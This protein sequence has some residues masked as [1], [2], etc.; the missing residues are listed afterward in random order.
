[1][2][3]QD[4]QRA[5]AQAA[6]Q[7]HVDSYEL[8]YQTSDRT[9]VRVF[10][11]EVNEFTSAVKGG[12]CLRCAIDGKMGYASTEELSLPAAEALVRRAADNAASLES[13]DPEFLGAA[14]QQYAI[15]DRPASQMPDT[16]TLIQTALQAQKAAYDADPA[17]VDGTTTAAVAQKVRIAISN[18]NGLDLSHEIVL[19]ALSQAAVVTDGTEKAD[20][21]VLK[22]GA[23]ETLDLP[24]VAAEAA[25]KAK[26][27]L[28]ADV[29]PTGVYP[30]VFA[31]EAMC[32]LLGTY[33]PVF[34]SENTQKGLSRLG[35]QE[36]QVIAA[37]LVTLVDDPCHP[38]NPLPMPFDDEG[39]PTRRK[40]VIE[41]GRL[42]TL[43]YNLKTAAAA[44]RETTGNAAKPSF[45]DKVS[46][47]PFTLYLAAGTLSEEE[48]LAKAGTGVYINALGGLHAGANVISG[49]FSLQS[50]GFLIEDGKKT[51]AV[52]SFTVAGNFYDLL[53]GITALS[54][55]VEL[56]EPDDTTTFGSPCVL[57]EGLSIAGK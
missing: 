20:A 28:G 33:A 50:S 52:K 49:D 42:N 15:I 4:F 51:K 11:S 48:L 32:A 12:V 2:E 10:G 8:Y 41:Q 53:K 14:G 29:A 40:N 36:G 27:K 43:L 9:A 45:S 47:S 38:D 57:V 46:V 21:Y 24:A 1:M 56:P 23:P 19:T 13:E 26:A 16:E 35:G 5:V 18:S 55:R 31:P 7:R 3:F 54:D 37:P 39:T 30:V 34:S 6:E 25:A 22:I 17:V 44:G